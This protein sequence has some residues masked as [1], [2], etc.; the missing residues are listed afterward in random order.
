MGIRAVAAADAVSASYDGGPLTGPMTVVAGLTLLTPAAGRGDDSDPG[1]ARFIATNA[2]LRYPTPHRLRPARIDRRHSGG[3]WHAAARRRKPQPGIFTAILEQAGIRPRRRW[4]SRQPD[5]DMVAAHRPMR[6]ILVLTGKRRR[7][8]GCHADGER[9]PDRVA[10]TPPRWAAPA[11]LADGRVLGHPG[12]AQACSAARSHRVDHKRGP[13]A[14][15]YALS[16]T[17]ASSR[18]LSAAGRRR[19]ASP[20]SARCSRRSDHRWTVSR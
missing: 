6:S 15:R 16:A 17:S 13:K 10:Q 14:R 2:D 1:C 3:Q 12:G 20:R 7:A 18:A 9:R 4:R 5:A 19:S 8:A 11:A